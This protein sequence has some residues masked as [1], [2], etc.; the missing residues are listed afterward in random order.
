MRGVYDTMRTI[1]FRFYKNNKL[2]GEQ[3]LKP[4]GIIDMAYEWD[5]ACQFTGLLDRIGKEIYEGDI[6]QGHPYSLHPVEVYWEQGLCSYEVRRGA[7]SSHCLDYSGENDMGYQ[8]L[9]VI[10]NIYEN[11]ELFEGNR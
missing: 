3:E 7:W 10:G 11:P 9:E 4:N 6:I 8:P 5:H 2:V 1:K